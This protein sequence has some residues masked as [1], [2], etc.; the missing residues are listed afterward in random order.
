MQNDAKNAY[1]KHQVFLAGTALVVLGLMALFFLGLSWMVGGEAFIE[2]LY[3][4]ETMVVLLAGVGVGGLL[5]LTCRD[6]SSSAGGSA[7]RTSGSAT[8]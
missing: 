2:S 7:M 1:A 6:K 8:A 5:M 4:K 3:G